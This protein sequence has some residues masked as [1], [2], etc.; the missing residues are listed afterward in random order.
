MWKETLMRLKHLDLIVTE[1]IVVLN[2]AF[3]LLPSHNPVIGTILAWPLVLVLPGY[4]LTAALY[5]KRSLDASHRLLLTLGLSLAI[6]ILSGLIL[7]VL[8]AGLQAT[9][10]VTL[11]GLLTVVFSLLVA[12][13][14]K[15]APV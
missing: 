9:S 13:L 4:M 15:R 1:I 11:L 10:W 12:Y 3:V 2:V 6:D 14:R 7:N 5:H 8:P